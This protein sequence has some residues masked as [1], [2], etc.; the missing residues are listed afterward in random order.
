MRKPLG[1]PD[2]GMK[3]F[4]PY[5][6]LDFL[7]RRTRRYTIFFPIFCR[8]LGGLTYVTELIASPPLVMEA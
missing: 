3:V 6:L 1:R 8:H 4:P 5:R 2:K 7:G